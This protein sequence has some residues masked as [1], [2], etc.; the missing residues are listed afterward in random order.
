MLLKSK[1]RNRF[2]LKDLGEVCLTIK[3]EKNLFKAK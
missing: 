3:E 2:L 1:S